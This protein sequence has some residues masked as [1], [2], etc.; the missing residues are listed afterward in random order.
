MFDSLCNS[1]FIK[2]PYHYFL[3]IFFRIFPTEENTNRGVITIVL[4]VIGVL[5]VVASI[6]V[7][8]KGIYKKKQ[9]GINTIQSMFQTV[10]S[11]CR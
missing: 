6:S 4:S 1:I 2:K 8:I 11:A 3:H 9:K 10:K 7:S 5:F